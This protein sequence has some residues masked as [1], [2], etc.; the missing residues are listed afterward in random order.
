LSINWSVRYLPG[1]ALPDKAVSIIDLAGA[2]ARR[3]GSGIVDVSSVA[4]VVAGLSDTPV[5]RLLEADGDRMLR[6]EEILA[7]RI[8]G[9]AANIGKIAGILR[10]NAAGLGSH[11]PIGTFLLLGPTGV[12]KTETAK[13]IAEVLFETDAAMTRIDFSEYSEAHSVAK[14]I[15]APPGYVGHDAGGQ[16]TEA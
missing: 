2:R 13:A 7:E 11:R 8:V 10:R 4:E 9:H 5:E 12:G 16:L 1:R 15:G 14:L 3:R 6:L